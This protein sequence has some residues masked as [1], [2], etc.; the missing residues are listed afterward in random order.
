VGGRRLILGGLALVALLLSGAGDA[1]IPRS[2]APPPPLTSRQAHGVAVVVQ[3]LDAF[4]A[5][6]LERALASFSAD[7]R[8]ARYV[9]VSDCDYRHR[10]SVAYSRRKAVAAWLRQRFADRDHLTMQ[11]IMFLTSDPASTYDKGAAVYYSRRAS[12]T[13]RVL[14][15]PRGIKPRGATKVGFTT[16]GPVRITQFA[17][18]G[19]DAD[20]Q[21]TPGPR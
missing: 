5:R 3:F 19:S 6:K 7:P 11:S 18:A 2:A 8:F 16:V 12:R 14:G 17:N 10:K 15:F 13:L 1:S 20:C 4:N 9:G 21:P